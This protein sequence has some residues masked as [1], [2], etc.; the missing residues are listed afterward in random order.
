MGHRLAT[1]ELTSKER[2]KLACAHRE[3]D[4][5][6]LQ[7]YFTPEIMARLQ[8]HFPGR[9]VREVLHLDLR[10]ASDAVTGGAPLKPPVP[11]VAD[12]Y[13]MWGVGY[14]RIANEFG[15]YDEASDLALARLKTMGDVRAYPWPDIDDY[16]FSGVEA[17]GDAIA[18]YAVC[19]GSAGIPDIVNGVSRGRGMEQVLMDIATG[20]E[21]GVA[22]IDRRVDFLYERCRRGLEA[23]KGKIDILC[24]GEDC[25]TQKGRL[26]SPAVFE[27]FFVPRMQRFI[28]LAHEHGA[29]AMLHSCGD[30]HEIM[31]TFIEMGLDILD[32][33]QP[34]PAGMDPETIKRDFG[35]RL[36]F[37]GLISTQETLPHGTTEEVRAEVRHRK[38]VIGRGGGYLLSP[39]HAIQPDTA[40]ENV[41]ALYQ[42]ALGVEEL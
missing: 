22:I 23:G 29:L 7:G 11:G 35:D 15:T 42:E 36:T 25:G 31:P 10:S 37:C 3:P 8:A 26:V 21:V 1:E 32:A 24:L 5:I 2:V 19:F 38:E 17:A 9:D 33:M 41:L 20:D 40:L 6:P 28:D 12:S 30:T 18:E 39:A 14:R 4:R 34:E 13:D 27:S 16:D